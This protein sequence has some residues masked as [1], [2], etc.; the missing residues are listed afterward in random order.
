[1]IE[2]KH[3]KYYWLLIAIIALSPLW[4]VGLFDRGYWTPD[5]PREA[6]I[7]WRMSIQHDRTLPQLAAVPFLEKPPLTYWLS[8]MAMHVF[9]DSASAARAPNLLYAVVVAFSIGVLM[10]SMGGGI[11]ACIAVLIA[12]SAFTAYQVSI[13]LAPDACL[14]AGCAISLLGLYR[15][16]SASDSQKKF[17]WYTLMHAGALIGFMAKSG[18]GWIYPGLTIV[19][20]ALWERRYKELVRWELWA[21]LV[22]QV[23]AI[24]TW[25]YGVVQLPDGLNDL[26]VLFW[27]NIVGRFTDLHAAGAL[28]YASGHKNWFGKYFVELPYYLFPWTLLVAAALHR[29]WR[30][31]RIKGPDGTPWRFALSASVPFVVLLSL[32]TT[33]RSIYVAPALLG[34]SVLVGVW[35]RTLES[36]PTLHDESALTA[37]RY[38]V[39]FFAVIMIVALGAM[40]MATLGNQASRNATH[41]IIAALGITLIASITLWRSTVFQ[42]RR[43]F[44]QSLGYAYIAYAASITVGSIALFPQF[45]QWQDLGSLA[46]TIHRDVGGN[47]FALFDA[48]ETTVAMMDHRLLS[49]FA[50]VDG[51]N[52]APQAVISWF[53]AH[54]DGRML[55]RLPGHATGPLTELFNRIHQQRPPGDDQLSVLEQ[56][57]AARL[58]AR[59]E[60][61]Q[62]RRY[63]LIEAP[64]SD[65]AHASTIKLLAA[66]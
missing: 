18:P 3:F 39:M 46:Q 33:A 15:G 50:I 24:G 54:P 44:Y 8:G 40:V 58:V 42:R 6:D 62:G 65:D 16:Y 59:Y 13:W 51:E 19:V 21:G 22:L 26:R 17:G 47:A 1:M 12:G 7:A 32:A 63:A 34:F 45:D 23:A 27:N 2:L 56:A 28:D 36:S 5:E 25:I 60:L 9:S 31:M 11:A 57:N 30:A 29:A 55:V 10:F 61:A 20:L 64:G 66:R 49:S 53:K 48:D 52:H 14:I 4:I 43:N 41:L 37:T 35:S 38:V